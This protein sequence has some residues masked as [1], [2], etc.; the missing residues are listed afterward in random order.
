MCEPRRLH[1]AGIVILIIEQIRLWFIP[2]IFALSW[3]GKRLVNWGVSLWWLTAIGTFLVLLAVVYGYLAWRRYT[4]RIEGGELRLVQ[5]VLFR[6]RSSIP[7][8][9]IQS[10]DSIQGVVH[11]LL[12]VVKIRVETAGGAGPEAE[13]AAISRAEADLLRQALTAKRRR[14]RAAVA[15]VGSEDGEG[16]EATER[17]EGGEGNEG[18][19]G[20]VNGVA[21]DDAYKSITSG[22]VT[23]VRSIESTPTYERQIT[24][25]ELFLLG[26]TSGSIGVIFSLIGGLLSKIDDILPNVNVYDR[27]FGMFKV[28]GDSITVLFIAIPAALLIAWGVAI[29]TMAIRYGQF[30]LQSTGEGL[31]I[32]RGLLER[33]RL[34]I[35]H[36]RIQA[37]RVVEGVLRQPF[38]YATVHI[39][40]AGYG[41]DDSE[42]TILFPLLKRD[43]VAAFLREVTPEFAVDGFYEQH[44][45]HRLPRRAL[46][47]QLR[48]W[49]FVSVLPAG[50]MTYFLFPWGALSLIIIPF[51]LL[52]GWAVFRDASWVY[53]EERLVLCTRRVARTMAIVTHRRVQSAQIRQSYFQR[54]KYLATF[55]VDVASGIG[56]KTFS[57]ADIEADEGA[58]LL[59]W[60]SHERRQARDDRESD[61]AHDVNSQADHSL[62]G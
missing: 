29:V 25:R 32:E 10:V 58:I 16:I 7:L 50:V 46:M 59:D 11:R 2:A 38:G 14:H 3:L 49:L 61:C 27:F 13:I 33:R 31:V 57:I 21:R 19:A 60:A 5:G 35:P 42:S 41:S 47:R 53:C 12:R 30:R 54:R 15:E 22:S 20:G 62:G 37:V 1:P 26:A 9:R 28:F 36:K 56:K 23:D 34:T 51:A 17:G 43:E 48:R 44:A 6:T 24:R 45:R 4:Y 40:S 52:Y 39:E 18:H 8:Q 55:E